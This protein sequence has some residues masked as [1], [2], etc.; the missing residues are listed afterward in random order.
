MKRTHES[1]LK[2]AEGEFF[3]NFAS[4]GTYYMRANLIFLNS[5]SINITSLTLARES[6]SIFETARIKRLETVKPDLVAFV[7]LTTLKAALPRILASSRGSSVQ[8]FS[9]SSVAKPF[10]KTHNPRTCLE[11]IS[12]V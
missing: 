3:F 4:E 11:N 1:F 10:W 6:R 8:D 5:A 9:H 12:K 7:T 2:R